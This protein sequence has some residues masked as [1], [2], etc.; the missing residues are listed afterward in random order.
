MSEEAK[1]GM[2]AQFWAPDLY[3]GGTFDHSSTP[4]DKKSLSKCRGFFVFRVY[5]ALL[6]SLI[7]AIALAVF[8]IFAVVFRSLSHAI[9]SSPIPAKIS[10]ADTARPVG[11]IISSLLIA[12]PSQLSDAPISL[13]D[14][15]RISLLHSLGII[16]P[17]S[18]FLTVL[19][20]LKQSA[21]VFSMLKPHCNSLKI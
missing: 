9:S 12:K 21:A 8:K 1:R 16:S 11:S 2:C 20:V 13:Y 3:Y 19:T 18:H 5:L 14:C 10:C 4:A 7:L 17:S 15:I 6:S